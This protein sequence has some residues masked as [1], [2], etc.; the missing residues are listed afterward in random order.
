MTSMETS[1]TEMKEMMKQMLEHSQS[2]SNTQQIANE[3]WNSVQPILKGIWLK[4][5]TTLIWNSLG[6]W[7]ML[8]T[9]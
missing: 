2:Q 9:R 3:L 8:G 7:L 6:I 4:S 5:T 1:M